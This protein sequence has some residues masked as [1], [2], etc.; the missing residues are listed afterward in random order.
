MVLLGPSWL[1][2]D[3]SSVLPSN[4]TSETLA[5]LSLWAIPFLIP[6]VSP[7]RGEMVPTDSC[8]WTLGHQLEVLIWG[9]P[10]TSTKW[11]FT[12]GSESL[13][14]VPWAFIVACPHLL[15]SVC[16]L[17]MDAMWPDSSWCHCYAFPALGLGPFFNNEPKQTFP[18]LSCFLSG[19]RLQPWEKSSIRGIWGWE[20][21]S[22]TPNKIL[23]LH[24]I[25]R[26]VILK[27]EKVP[28]R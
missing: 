24:G 16:S 5:L 19:I 20:L 9:D 17:D 18:S 1:F 11:N 23:I 7:V 22:G 14:G 21:A 25:E 4:E 8:V 26:V 3:I 15:S 27:E 28:M 10:G 12:G 2:Q 13:G 6:H